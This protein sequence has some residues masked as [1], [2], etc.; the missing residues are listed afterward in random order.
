MRNLIITILLSVF[1]S[2]DCFSQFNNDYQKAFQ[3]YRENKFEEAAPYFKRLINKGNMS[4]YFNLYIDCLIKTKQ[5]K[6]GV[7]EIKRAMKS[8]KNNR[9]SYM[10]ELGHI[11]RYTES[12]ESAIK[13]F[14]DVII[15]IQKTTWNISQISNS[16][17][18]KREYQYAAKVFLKHRELMGDENLYA[19]DLSNIY[20]YQ[21]NHKQM[22]DELLKYVLQKGMGTYSTAISTIRR[23]LRNEDRGVIMPMI[24]Q[25]IIT[26]KQSN[27]NKVVLDK[28]LMWYYI[29]TNNFE[30]AYLYANAVFKRTLDTNTL[31]SFASEAIQNNQLDVA[32]KSYNS[33]LNYSDKD[34]KVERVKFSA[35]LKLLY[36]QFRKIDADYEFGDEY[37][38]SFIDRSDKIV[39]QRGINNLTLPLFLNSCHVKAFV[40]GSSDEPL[41]LLKLALKK[42]LARS[43]IAK[44]KMKLADILIAGDK[45]WE[46]IIYLSQVIDENGNSE[47]AYKARYKKAEL[48]FYK[49]DFEW[50]LAQ[51]NILKASTDKYIA[52]DAMNLAMFI[53][54]NIED[55]ENLERVAKAKFLMDKGEDSVAVSMLDSV[56]VNATSPLLDNVGM[57]KA[58]HLIKKNQSREAETELLKII[59]NKENNFI[60]DKA[61]F[62]LAQIYETKME[63][64]SEAQKLYKT[65]LTEYKSSVYID[66]ARERYRGMEKKEKIEN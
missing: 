58:E 6:K 11:T 15:N 35:E 12:N 43:A 19:Y 1:I 20:L 25:K 3:L 53:S 65:L 31:F 27:P 8:D 28:L 34:N 24:E 44:I 9:L 45:L 16:F 36:V 13:I 56:I 17:I 21:R 63:R 22:M 66:K 55:S 30:D 64:T 14:D 23:S 51:L 59:K 54:D 7:K 33:V 41:K 18:N 39:M 38:D 50:T 5:Y 29:E 49:L 46:A 2:V 48:S 10:V 40:Q 26:V 4:Y 32:E 60:S 62:L 57:I 42:R 37:I 52:N 61:L 47:I